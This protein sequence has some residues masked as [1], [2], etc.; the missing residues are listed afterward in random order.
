MVAGG[1]FELPAGIDN[2]SSE[3]DF[4]E[5]NSTVCFIVVLTRSFA[6]RGKGTRDVH[7]GREYYNSS[8][9]VHTLRRGYIS[10]LD[11]R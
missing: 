4:R 6:A 2:T 5:E 8:F 1:G 9:V 7:S 10:R 11:L 3:G